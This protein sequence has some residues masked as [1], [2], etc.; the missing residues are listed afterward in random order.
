MF[1]KR[2]D[3]EKWLELDSIVPSFSTLFVG[4]PIWTKYGIGYYLKSRG[5]FTYLSMG[6]NLRLILNKEFVFPDNDIDDLLEN[7]S[8]ENENWE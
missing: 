6:W 5:D 2:R 3:L 4:K 8:A 1:Y 7:N